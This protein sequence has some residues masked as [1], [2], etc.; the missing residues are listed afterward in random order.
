MM[1]KILV[2][3]LVIF[4]GANISVTHS[5]QAE[6]NSPDRILNW[7]LRIPLLVRLSVPPGSS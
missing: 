6:E 2:W 1:K 7:W 5:Q 4:F 3:L